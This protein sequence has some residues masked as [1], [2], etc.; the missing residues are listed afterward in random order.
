MLA[1]HN[2]ALEAH[3]VVTVLPVTMNDVVSAVFH[4]ILTAMDAVVS[5]APEEDRIFDTIESVVKVLYV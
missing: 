3:V 5:V 2:E 1:V 4:V